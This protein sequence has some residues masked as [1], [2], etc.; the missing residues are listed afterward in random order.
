MLVL[1]ARSKW[2]LVTQLADGMSHLA[3]HVMYVYLPVDIHSGPCYILS[4]HQWSPLHWAAREG[5]VN[6]VKCLVENGAEVNSE[7]YNGVNFTT[8]CWLVQVWVNLHCV[9]NWSHTWLKSV[10]TRSDS[11]KNV[12]TSNCKEYMHSYNAE[13]VSLISITRYTHAH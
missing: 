2:T 4:P 12:N 1:M 3:L 8:D 11:S 5:H 7:D 6:T 9:Y 10:Y 13:L